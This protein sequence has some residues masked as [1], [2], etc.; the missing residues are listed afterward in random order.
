MKA[1][2]YPVLLIYSK[3]DAA[4]LARVDMLPGCIADGITQEE[5][6]ANAKVAIENWIAVS[7]EL[8]RDIPKALDI[9]ELEDLQLK[10]MEFQGQQIQ[11]LIQQAVAQVIQQAQA[12]IGKL[13]I[14]HEAQFGKRGFQ[15]PVPQIAGFTSQA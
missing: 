14:G 3:D 13:P 9:Q 7:K 1:T 8:S 10:A 4:W 12:G 11:N 2:D 6:L 5:A 15:M